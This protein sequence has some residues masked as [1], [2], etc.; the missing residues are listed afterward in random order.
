MRGVHAEVTKEELQARFHLAIEDC[1]SVVSRLGVSPELENRIQTGDARG[2]WPAFT[3][4]SAD[5]P[6]ALC[7]CCCR[8]TFVHLTPQCKQV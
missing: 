4:P 6:A 7:D 3:R 1:A 2:T 5:G 8:A